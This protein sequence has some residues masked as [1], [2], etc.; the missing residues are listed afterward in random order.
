MRVLTRV[1]TRQFPLS[2][3]KLGGRIR[4]RS[5]AMRF[6]QVDEKCSHIRLSRYLEILVVY[7]VARENPAHLPP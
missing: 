4:A 2:W 6:D 5:R 3:I 7:E 1:L